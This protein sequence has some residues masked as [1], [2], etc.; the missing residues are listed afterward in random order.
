LSAGAYREIPQ[1]VLDETV[2]TRLSFAGAQQKWPVYVRDGRLFFPEVSF[3]SSHILKFGSDRFKALPRNEAY[4]TFLAGKT[5]PAGFCAT[6]GCR[7]HGIS[8]SRF[9]TRCGYP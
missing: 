2:R 7:R 6:M 8:R 4:V 9:A 3:A 1:E 5:T